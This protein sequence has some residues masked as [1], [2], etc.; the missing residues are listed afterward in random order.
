MLPTGNRPS[1]DTHTSHRPHGIFAAPQAY[2]D[3]SSGGEARERKGIAM[4]TFSRKGAEVRAVRLIKC[5]RLLEQ[6]CYSA[7]ALA[8]H[9][10]VSKRTVYRDLRLLARAGVPLMRQTIDKG[11]HVP[12]AW[13]EPE[14]SVSA[15][16]ASQGSEGRKP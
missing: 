15:V 9:F 5:L 6:A 13:Q 2:H 4:N 7:E 8:D 1:C 12:A 3:K 10:A 16:A 14:R 11:Y